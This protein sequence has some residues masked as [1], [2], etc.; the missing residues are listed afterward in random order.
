MGLRVKRFGVAASFHLAVIG[1]GLIGLLLGRNLGISGMVDSGVMLLVVHLL[2]FRRAPLDRLLGERLLQQHRCGQ[3]AL[4]LHL[5]SP[6]RCGCGF[7]SGE[8]H[9]F[10]HCPQCGKGFAWLNCP[11]CGAGILV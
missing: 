2:T 7:T 1:L 5:V 9:V 11:R 8:R 4:E 3:C 10:S 6:W